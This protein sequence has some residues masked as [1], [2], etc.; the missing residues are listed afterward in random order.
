MFF[1]AAQGTQVTTACPPPKVFAA[2]K[3]L[4]LASLFIATVL[5]FPQASA[6]SLKAALINSIP[7]NKNQ[8]FLTQ[9]CLIRSRTLNMMH[10]TM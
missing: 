9:A 4:L 7:L 2:R 8:H 1:A 3:V 5:L 6:V 10:V